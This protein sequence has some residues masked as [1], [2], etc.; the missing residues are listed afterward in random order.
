MSDPACYLGTKACGCVSFISAEKPYLAK[1]I[2]AD[3]EH[4]IA[5]GGKVERGEMAEMKAR[6]VGMPWSCAACAG[7]EVSNG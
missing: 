3:T 7:E 2:A 4:L 6:L 1:E 5:H